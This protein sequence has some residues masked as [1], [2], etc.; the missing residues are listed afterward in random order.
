VLDNT[1][2]LKTIVPYNAAR[3]YAPTCGPSNAAAQAPF[4]LT[5]PTF[6][7]KATL[8]KQKV[9]VI[10]PSSGLF[11]ALLLSISGIAMDDCERWWSVQVSI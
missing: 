3:L 8:I 5:Q 10:P 9:L 2:E 7:E 1:S 6:A 4:P 11:S